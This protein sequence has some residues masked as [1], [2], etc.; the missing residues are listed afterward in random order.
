M[1]FLERGFVLGT[2][3]GIETKKLIWR[4]LSQLEAC[5]FPFYLLRLW[6]YKAPDPHRSE[7]DY[8]EELIKKA[9]DSEKMGLFREVLWTELG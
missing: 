6:I 5:T 7:I 8:V 2:G 4:P 9:Y 3:W 1:A